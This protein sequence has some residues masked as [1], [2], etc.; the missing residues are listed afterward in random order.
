MAKTEGMAISRTQATRAGRVI[1]QFSEGNP[2]Y[3]ETDY[4]QAIETLQTWRSQFLRPT[5]NAFSCLIHDANQGAV[6]VVA[7]YRLK[8]QTSIVKKLCRKHSHYKLGELDDIGGCRLIVNNLTDLRRVVTTIQQDSLLGDEGLTKHKD[9]I[10]TPETSG[11]RSYHYLSRIANPE[12]PGKNYR[13]EIQIRTFL[14]HYWATALETFSE[15]SGINLKD[16]EVLDRTSAAAPKIK[17]YQTVFA[18]ISQLFAL[19]EDTGL[20]SGIPTN[21]KD[22]K[23]YLQNSAVFRT[24]IDELSAAQGEVSAPPQ[25]SQTGNAK[26]F[27]LEFSPSDQMINVQA[28]SDM[29]A[30]LKAY[31]EFENPNLSPKEAG[32][33]TKQKDNN[34]DVQIQHELELNTNTVLA[35]AN[36]RDN[37]ERAYPN[38]R[39]DQRHFLEALQSFDLR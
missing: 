32:R 25:A 23:S 30:A 29:G 4:S 17:T 28:F 27:L 37:L 12:D 34:T 7:S 8:R 6:P 24:I 16:P 38:Y 18:Y 35:Y 39:L 26:L 36:G 33:R 11:Y 21:E 2:E 19:Q 14:E 22:I 31:D 10:L 9:Y 5:E 3:S 13:V 1:A 20:I 15:I